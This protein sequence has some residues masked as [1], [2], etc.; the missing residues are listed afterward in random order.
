MGGGNISA[1]TSSASK[2]AS[3]ELPV[4]H[5]PEALQNLAPI[6]DVTYGGLQ[7]QPTS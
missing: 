2:S 4:W 5:L 1:A 7:L 6:F 3:A